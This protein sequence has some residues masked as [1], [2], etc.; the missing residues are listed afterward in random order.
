MSR[1]HTGT[2]LCVRHGFGGFT[3]LTS[4]SLLFFFFCCLSFF[5]PYFSVSL[6]P[7]LSPLSINSSLSSSPSTSAPLPPI[8]FTLFPF[9]SPLSPYFF[10]SPSIYPSSAP[11]SS[12]CP[13]PVRSPSWPPLLERLPCPTDTTHCSHPPKTTSNSQRHQSPQSVSQAVSQPASKAASQPAFC[14][15]L[16][17]LSSQSQG[18]F[19]L[20]IH[21]KDPLKL[22]KFAF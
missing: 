13:D 14:F 11:P 21:I 20:L 3:S 8:S 17:L 19:P 9:L 4:V 7:P 1:P 2:G 16:K 5:S 18:C 22:P 12:G 6:F 10:P 15:D